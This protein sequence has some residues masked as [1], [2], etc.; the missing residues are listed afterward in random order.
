MT[1]EDFQINY[2]K[3]PS[4]QTLRLLSQHNY[5]KTFKSLGETVKL[6]NNFDSQVTLN[7][8]KSKFLDS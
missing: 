4:Q 1:F 6:Q 3:L 2:L 5:M 7:T 8:S